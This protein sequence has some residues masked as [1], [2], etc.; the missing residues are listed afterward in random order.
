MQAN[1]VNFVPLVF[2]FRLCDSCAPVKLWSLIMSEIKDMVMPMLQSIQTEQRAM[3]A[4]VD[5]IAENVAEIKDELE[6]IKGFTTFHMGLTTQNQSEIADLRK[7]M[8]DLKK[9][10]AALEGR[11]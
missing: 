6:T 4:R 9:R 8:A 3:R 10:M 1:T 2:F 11:G 7:D 5:G